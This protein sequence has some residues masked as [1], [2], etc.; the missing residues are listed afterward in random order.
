[1]IAKHN[2]LRGVYQGLGATILRNIPSFSLYFGECLG[3]D[4]S[5]SGKYRS[6]FSS[7]KLK[8]QHLVDALNLAS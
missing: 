4:K 8:F 1:M 7:S 5:Y 2:G 3:I 6:A